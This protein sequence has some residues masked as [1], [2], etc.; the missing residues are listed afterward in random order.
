MAESQVLS[1]ADPVT[2]AGERIYWEKY[3]DQY[4][5]THL[6]KF[7]AIDVVTGRATLSEQAADAME[8]AHQANPDHLVYLL[9]IGSSAIGRLGFRLSQAL[10]SRIH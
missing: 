6:G 7:L 1:S 2:E 8:R 5:P 10:P 4:E 9:K 3:R